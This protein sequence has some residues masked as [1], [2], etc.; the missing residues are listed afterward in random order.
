MKDVA[1][2]LINLVALVVVAAII[3]LCAALM[4]S[5]LILVFIGGA[6]V[7]VAVWIVIGVSAFSDWIGNIRQRRRISRAANTRIK[8]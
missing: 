3:V 6:I 2:G 4:W 5:S 8:P 7:F 1:T